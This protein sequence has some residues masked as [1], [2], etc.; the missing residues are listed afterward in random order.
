MNGLFIVMAAVRMV[1]EWQ[2]KLHPIS[3][4]FRQIRKDMGTVAG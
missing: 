3:D 1:A 4:A 2:T